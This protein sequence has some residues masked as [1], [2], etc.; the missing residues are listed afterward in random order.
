M[1]GAA[2]CP[3]WLPPF[4]LHEILSYNIKRSPTSRI[5]ECDWLGKPMMVSPP[6]ARHKT[7]LSPTGTACGRETRKTRYAFDEPSLVYFQCFLFNLAEELL[8]KCPSCCSMIEVCSIRGHVYFQQ[9]NK[10]RVYDRQAGSCC[11]IES[12]SQL[13]ADHFIIPT[14]PRSNFGH[15]PPGLSRL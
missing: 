3:T 9:A 13:A 12:M 5:I 2:I 15:A 8:I 4:V 10:F 14:F 1:S 7:D 6:W 11:L